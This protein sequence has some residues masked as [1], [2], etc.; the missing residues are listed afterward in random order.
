MRE[1]RQRM[2]DYQL[3]VDAVP[4][5]ESELTG[6]MR[7]YDT[8]QKIYADLLSKKENSQ[9]S[10]NLERQQV[11]EQ[12]KVIDPARLPEEPFSPNPRAHRADRR[13]PG[14]VPRGRPDRH[15]RVPRQTLRTEDEIVRTL[16]LPV[17]AAIPLMTAIADARRRQRN[18]FLTGAVTAMTLVGLSLAV[19]K[20]VQ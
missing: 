19:W 13:G 10:A 4:G 8:L 16:M 15:R 11:G 18:R 20:L 14:T 9:I 7:D 17:I 3:R 12:F 6:L 2:S 5:H 1:L